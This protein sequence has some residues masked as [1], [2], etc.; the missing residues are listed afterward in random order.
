M[1]KRSDIVTVTRVMNY[2]RTILMYKGKV[3]FSKCLAVCQKQGRVRV[4][5]QEVDTSCVQ[6]TEIIS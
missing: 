5:G 1:P 3:P 2:G 6:L 4:G